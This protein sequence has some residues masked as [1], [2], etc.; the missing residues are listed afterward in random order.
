MSHIR[1]YLEATAKLAAELDEACIEALT[2]VLERAW[3]DGRRIFVCG[4]GGSASLATHLACDLNKNCAQPGKPRLKI[5]SLTDNLP[6]LTAYANDVS[7]A[8]VFVEQLVNFF[9]PGDV[10]MGISGSG[11]SENVVRALRWAK[12]HGGETLGLLAFGGGRCAP[13][14]DV[15]FIAPTHDMQHAEDA[16]TIVTHLLM[17]LFSRKVADC[18]VG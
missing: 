9:E 11:N 4:N 5:L 13:L 3:R 12:E 10:V 18:H 7:Y 15:A 6:V 8:D 2:A 16:H 14:C 17:Q 1:T